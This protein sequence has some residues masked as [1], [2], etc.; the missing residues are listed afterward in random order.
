MRIT[1]EERNQ[2]TLNV[3]E[4]AAALRRKRM[5]DE[6]EEEEEAER[7]ET[8]IVTILGCAVAVGG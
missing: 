3:S 8:G 7:S 1:C 5:Q 6:D 2:R 4:N